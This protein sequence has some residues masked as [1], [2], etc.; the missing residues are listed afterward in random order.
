MLEDH[1]GDAFLAE[2]T[3]GVVAE[4]VEPIGQQDDAAAALH[5]RQHLITAID[6]ALVKVGFGAGFEVPF[7]RL[8]QRGLIAGPGRQQLN[9]VAIGD[10]GGAV[11]FAERVDHLLRQVAVQVD[12]FNGLFAA[13]VQ[14]EQDVGGRADDIVNFVT[15][16]VFVDDEI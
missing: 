11:V 10:D 6:Q 9:R 2:L 15:L 16:P 12:V 14:N 7:Q 13:G 1:F 3:A 8:T 5:F 4:L